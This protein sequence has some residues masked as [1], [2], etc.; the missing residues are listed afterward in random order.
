MQGDEEGVKLVRGLR[1][2]YQYDGIF[3]DLP[4]SRVPGR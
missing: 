2:W 4:G 3:Q 1:E